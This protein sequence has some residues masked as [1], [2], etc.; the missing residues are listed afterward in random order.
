MEGLGITPYRYRQ[1]LT[2]LFASQGFVPYDTTVPNV[3]MEP[4]NV[5]LVRIGK[6]VDERDKERFLRYVRRTPMV[7]SERR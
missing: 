1:M 5:L 7:Y 3:M 6:R 4:A 2:H